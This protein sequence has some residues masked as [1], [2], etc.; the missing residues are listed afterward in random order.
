MNRN[1][2][3]DNTNNRGQKKEGNDSHRNTTRQ[4]PPPCYANRRDP[5][6]PPTAMRKW[7]R[8]QGMVVK[9]RSPEG[10]VG[11]MSTETGFLY[12]GITTEVANKKS[13]GANRFLMLPSL[14]CS[15]DKRDRQGLVY[16]LTEEK[17]SSFRD[18]TKVE[19]MDIP[20]EFN[21]IQR[22]LDRLEKLAKRNPEMPQREV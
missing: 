4:L 18:D 3:S 14:G 1:S 9:Q 8:W 2:N 6:S 13:E 20:E 5:F 17:G 11:N 22:D 10:P 12:Q 21:T 15:E 16:L 19:V 7:K